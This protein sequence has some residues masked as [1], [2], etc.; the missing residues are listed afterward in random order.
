MSTV[1][2]G[3]RQA[4]WPGAIPKP[5]APYSPAIKAGGWL[6]VAGQLASDCETGLAPECRLA[7]PNAG[8]PLRLQSDYVLKN[9]AALHEA[10]G[11]DMRTDVARIYQWF[12][13]PYPTMDELV[14]GN[15]WPR[16]SITPYLDTRNLYIDE[17]RPASTGMGIR[18]DGLLVR[19]TILEVDMISMEGAV[20]LGKKGHAVP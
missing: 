14:E 3:D 18:E 20:A 16:I 12:A 11:M 8:D 9:L 15:T 4:V 13:S 7:N 5:L 19:N 2:S 1:Q 6:F 10:A 17:P